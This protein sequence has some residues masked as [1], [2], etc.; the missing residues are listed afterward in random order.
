MD[1]RTE[2]VNEERDDWDRF[3]VDQAS[4][5]GQDFYWLEDVAR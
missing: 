3:S 2:D 4:D 1:D 5:L